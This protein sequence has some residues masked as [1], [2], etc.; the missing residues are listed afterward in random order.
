MIS[1]RGCSRPSASDSM[2]SGIS[3]ATPLGPSGSPMSVEVNTSRDSLPSA[4]PSCEPNAMPPICDIIA[5]SGPAMLLASSGSAEAHTVEICSAT[6]SH[7]RF[8]VSRVLSIQSLGVHA[9]GLGGAR[10]QRGRR[11]PARSRP[12]ARRRRSPRWSA[13]GPARRSRSSWTPA[14]GPG[15]SSPGRTAAAGHRAAGAAEHL[16]EPGEDLAEVGH[17]EVRRPAEAER[18]RPRAGSGSFLRL[19]CGR[20]R[21]RRRSRK[22]GQPCLNGTHRRRS[23]CGSRV[24]L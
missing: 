14:G 17:V 22:A 13:P 11:R 23:A 18:I 3:A 16:A 6:G 4:W 15:R 9:D 19:V 5:S 1:L 7:S 20:G 8:Q 2:A 12:G 10:G 21:L 24:T